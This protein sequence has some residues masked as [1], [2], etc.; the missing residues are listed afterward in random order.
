MLF[1]FRP[2]RFVEVGPAYSAKFARSAIDD[3]SLQSRI[4]S[5]DPA[6]RAE[7]DRLCDSV[8]RQPL[9]LDLSV[10]GDLEP[11]DFLFIDSLHRT[12]S[13]SDVTVVLWMCCHGFE[14]ELSC[15]FTKPYD[16]LP[17]WADQYYSEQYLLGSYLHGA[18]ISK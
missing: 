9:E 13:N 2:E 11:G 5:I 7:I 4:T 15:I 8:I 14:P 12:F 17:E 18:D 3:H 1:E 10:F 6:S 16:Y